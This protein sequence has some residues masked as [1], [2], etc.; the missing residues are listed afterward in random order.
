MKVCP[1]CDCELELIEVDGETYRG[2][3]SCKYFETKPV[4]KSIKRKK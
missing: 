1:F 3:Q 2:C 4:E